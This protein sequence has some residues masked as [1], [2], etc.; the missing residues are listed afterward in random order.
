MYAV[1]YI[2]PKEFD[3][4]DSTNNKKRMFGAVES[5]AKLKNQALTFWWPK[6]EGR[7]R[8]EI[9]EEIFKEQ[10]GSKWGR[11]RVENMQKH[12]PTGYVLRWDL[13]YD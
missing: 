13:N 9:L 3:D 10:D 7:N 8:S 6:E 2:Q 4:H 11:I 12:I 5:T 1:E